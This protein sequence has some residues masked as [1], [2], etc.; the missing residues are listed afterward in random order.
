MSL[1]TGAH[2]DFIMQQQ[3]DIILVEFINSVQTLSFTYEEWLYN[4][5]EPIAQPYNEF[6][7]CPGC[8][9]LLPNFLIH[10]LTGFCYGCRGD[11]DLM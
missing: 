5:I 3:F 7:R 1:P 9:E 10:T 2:S 4:Q 6:N 11:D 8:G